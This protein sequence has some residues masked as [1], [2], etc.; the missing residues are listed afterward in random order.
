MANQDQDPDHRGQPQRYVQ[1]SGQTHG[2]NPSMQGQSGYRQPW[3]AD[4]V[5]NSGWGGQYGSGS[6]GQGYGLYQSG[7]PVNAGGP[8]GGGFSGMGGQ[9][10]FGGSNGPQ[11]G[12]QHQGG[13][14]GGGQESH[15]PAM[16]GSGTQPG[17]PPGG[18][19][20]Q[21]DPHYH[22]WRER[23]NR[24]FDEDWEAFNRERQQSFD[25]EFE[26]WRTNRPARISEAQAEPGNSSPTGHGSQAP[27]MAGG[28]AS[29]ASKDTK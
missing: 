12:N 16:Q 1:Q 14:F 29:T 10:G 27:S 3:G 6:Y 5:G 20:R 28:S 23:Q 4:A 9:G 13:I 25:D 19:P 2:A 15:G 8:V 18:Q 22:A 17:N 24:Q 7:Q 21:H 11:L 26:K